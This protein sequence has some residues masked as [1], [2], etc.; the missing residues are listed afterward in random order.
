MLL[1]IP[2]Y[3]FNRID[4]DIIKIFYWIPCIDFVT[5]FIDTKFL[6]NHYQISILLPD[7][8]SNRTPRYK[9]RNDVPSDL[10]EMA[11]KLWLLGLSKARTTI[12][13]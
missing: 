4:Q 13:M 7:L 10:W 6:L 2:T 1:H 12:P 11:V 3:I 9:N 5:L 8:G